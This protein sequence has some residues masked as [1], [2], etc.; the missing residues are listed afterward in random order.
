MIR[1]NFNVTE[2]EVTKVSQ[3]GDSTTGS[4]GQIECTFDLD[5]IYNDMTCVAVFNEV[6]I[7]MIRGVCY[8]D[9]IPEGRCVVGVYAYSETDGIID[10]RISPKPCIIVVDRGSYLEGYDPEPPTASE[11]ERFYNLINEAIS[12]GKIKGEKGDKGDPGVVRD[13]LD[14]KRVSL[15]NSDGEAI[16]PLAKDDGTPGLL[17]FKVNSG[18]YYDNYTNEIKVKF[19]MKSFVDYFGGQD[20][21]IKI[22][23]QRNCTIMLLGKSFVTRGIFVDAVKS[24]VPTSTSDL[25]NDSHFVVDESYTHTDNNYTDE[26]KAKLENDVATKTEVD[27]ELATKQDKLSDEQITSIANVSDKQDKLTDEQIAKLDSDLATITYVD[28]ETAKKQDTLTA[29]QLSNISA[30]PNKQDKLTT[31]QLNNISVVSNKQDKLTTEQLNN[32][33]AVSNK[34]DKLTTDQLSNI[35]AVPNKQDKLTDAQL[36]NIEAVTSKQDKLIAGTNIKIENNVISL[37]I[38]TATAE[39]LYGGDTQ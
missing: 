3:V 36:N 5:P 6:K 35:S 17:A 25:E 9:N 38:E 2:D 15:L 27:T 8:A 10:K 29:T 1:I 12:S 22:D 21:K 4:I 13:V 32:I 39:T 31:E 34:Q 20:F 23:D 30:V 26:E 14:Y 24:L 28:G 18:L 16:I 7:P 37:D 33:S 19:P 11:T